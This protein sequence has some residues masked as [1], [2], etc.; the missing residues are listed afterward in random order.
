MPWRKRRHEWRNLSGIKSMVHRCI[1]FYPVSFVTAEETWK[2]HVWYMDISTSDQNGIWYPEK[3]RVSFVLSKIALKIKQQE[4]L[5]CYSKPWGARIAYYFRLKDRVARPLVGKPSFYEALYQAHR[6]VDWWRKIPSQLTFSGS[7]QFWAYSRPTF[8]F[9]PTSGW[10]GG[11]TLWFEDEFTIQ[12]CHKSR[13][14]P[15]QEV[16]PKQEVNQKNQKQA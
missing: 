9:R 12:L 2:E 8:C 4:V 3:Y 10:L 11:K 16:H 13:A 14:L 1:L 15:Q 5:Q 7:F 6:P